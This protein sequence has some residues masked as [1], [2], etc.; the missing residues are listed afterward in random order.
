MAS[1]LSAVVGRLTWTQKACA[2]V[3]AGMQ[4]WTRYNMSL[5]ERTPDSL[6]GGQEEP[7]RGDGVN[8]FLVKEKQ[9]AG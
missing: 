5:K 8:R 7:R 1:V 9:W 4:V 6:W 3:G 2:A